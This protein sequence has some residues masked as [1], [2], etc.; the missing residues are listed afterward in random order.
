MLRNSP[1]LIACI[2]GVARAGLV[3]VPINPELRSNSLKYVIE[4]AEPSLLI[5]CDDSLST[6]HQSHTDLSRLTTVILDESWSMDALLQCQCA[7]L[8]E[9]PPSPDSLFSIMYTSGTTGQPKGVLV[10]HKMICYAAEAAILLADTQDGD[11]LYMWEPMFHVAGAQVL[12]MPLRQDLRIAL[13]PRFSASRFWDD[14]RSTGATH[15][16]YLG[17]VLQILMKQPPSEH[18]LN[19]SARVAWGAGCA[20]D[21]WESFQQRFGLSL[22]ESYGMTETSSIASFNGSAKVASVG[23]AVPWFTIRVLDAQGQAVP[24]GELGEIVVTPK[25]AGSVFAGYFRN[26]ETTA[27]YC[28][29]VRSTPKTSALLMPMA[30]CFSTAA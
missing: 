8:N 15:I 16:H 3:W 11:V 29:T 12:F 2:F 18:D 27:T 17:G 19:H 4:H 9:A 30:I 20:P 26:E 21:I 14:V 5:A 22:R 25:E 7:P 24:P 6:V 13:T 23:N 10:T 1:E 28:A